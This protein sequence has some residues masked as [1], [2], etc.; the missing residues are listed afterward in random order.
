MSVE[1]RADGT[2]G[3]TTSEPTEVLHLLTSWA[4]NRPD[5]IELDGLTVSRPSLEDVYLALTTSE[6]GDAR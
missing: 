4:R 5:P 6:P 2:V 1:E 3:F